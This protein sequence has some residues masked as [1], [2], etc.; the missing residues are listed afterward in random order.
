MLYSG[1]GIVKVAPYI[2]NVLSAF[3]DLQNVPD[4]SV[5]M[6]ED[7]KTLKE[8]R[9][10]ARAQL[11]RLTTGQDIS[12][13]ATLNDFQSE[14]LRIAVR[15]IDAVAVTAG[16]EDDPVTSGTGLIA[17]AKIDL[18]HMNVLTA[19]VK[20]SKTGTA[21][22]LVAGVDYE[23]DPDFGTIRL[24]RVTDGT[25]PYVQPFVITGVTYG[26]TKQVSLFSAAKLTYCV[27]FVGVNTADSNKKTLVE[28]YRVEFSPAAQIALISDDYG[29]F[30]IEGSV[31]LDPTKDAS[32]PLGQFGRIVQFG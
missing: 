7:V 29:K 23:L 28:L 30:D 17:G 5:D 22:T 1:Q 10:G 8:S 12:V 26:G 3:I 9:S 4:F 24:L 2:N 15:S 16:S 20:D 6:K 25:T 27:R 13:K 31:L 11:G 21:N 19:I 18:G 14:N 32:G